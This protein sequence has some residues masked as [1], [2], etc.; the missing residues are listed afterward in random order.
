MKARII[1][2]AFH[3]QDSILERI[4]AHYRS[5]N[6]AYCARG[7]RFVI[8]NIIVLFNRVIEL[9]ILQNIAVNPILGDPYIAL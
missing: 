2:R 5:R 8:L 7:L 6:T 3:T 4:L 9:V 1:S